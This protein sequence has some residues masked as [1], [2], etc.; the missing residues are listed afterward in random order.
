MKKY[1]IIDDKKFKLKSIDADD[2]DGVESREQ[3]EKETGALVQKIADH[4]MRLHVDGTHALLVVLQGMDGSGKDGTIRRVFGRVNPAGVF[5]QSFKEPT[6]LEL[7]HD[8]LW[9]VH[10]QVPARGMI[11]VFNRSYYEDVLIVRV[12]QDELL[13]AR[14]K[15]QKDL[16]EWRFELINHFEKLLVRD[17][18]H[19]LKFFLHI[20]KNEQRRRFIDRQQTPSKQWKFTSSDLHERRFW[21][22][23]QKAY[24]DALRHTGTESAPWYIVPS[25]KKW[26]RNWVIASTIAKT[27]GKLDLHPPEIEDKE[28]LKVKILCGLP[29]QRQNKILKVST[30]GIR[31]NTRKHHSQLFA[32]FRVFK[33][34][35]ARNGFA[36][37]FYTKQKLVHVRQSC[38]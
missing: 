31:R 35:F 19:I 9:R 21:N 38:I 24:E 32:F 7:H 8:F 2:T 29:D 27:L 23:Y 18:V 11:G 10:Q 33:N 3:A 6:P 5:V 16:W 30:P 36:M 20:S 34:R 28:L 25:D 4:Q 1:K 37:R 12:H 17:G 15:A 26:Y 22:D 14:L 13:P